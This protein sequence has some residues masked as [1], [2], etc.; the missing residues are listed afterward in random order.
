M[1]SFHKIKRARILALEDDPNY[2]PIFVEFILQHTEK[3][4]DLG[5]LR[6]FLSND[7]LPTTDH[8][9]LNKAKEKIINQIKEALDFDVNYFIE[10]F[11][12]FDESIGEYKLKIDDI[13][14]GDAEQLQEMFSHLE[15][16]YDNKYGFRFEWPNESKYTL[17]IDVCCKISKYNYLHFKDDFNC[18]HVKDNLYIMLLNFEELKRYLKEKGILK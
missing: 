2:G 1:S 18:S 8:Y 11:C 9:R 6:E 5:T 4:L 3:F 7:Q 13:D 15:N 17:N 12:I 14:Y 10:Y 16:E